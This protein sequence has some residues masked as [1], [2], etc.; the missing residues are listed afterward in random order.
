MNRTGAGG[1]TKGQSGNPGGRPREIG[2]I[3][4]L[5]RCHT[6]AAFEALRGIMSD[7]KAP[8]SARVAAA[9]AILNRGWGRPSQI[10]SG[11]AEAEPLEIVVRWAGQ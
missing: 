8:P 1:F 11:D 6:S 7:E 2:E 3:K 10:V 4:E 9:E 5:A